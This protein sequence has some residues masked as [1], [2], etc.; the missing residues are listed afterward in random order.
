[1]RLLIVDDL[2][3]DNVKRLLEYANKHVFS[4]DDLLDIYNKQAPVIGDRPEFVCEIP[5]GFRVVYNH[6]EQNIG[7][8]KHISISV[9]KPGAL[10]NVEAVKEILRLFNIETSLEDCDVRLEDGGQLKSINVIALK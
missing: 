3:R 1:M 10:P 9:D 8:V 4:M 5:V 7:V 6:E 2:V